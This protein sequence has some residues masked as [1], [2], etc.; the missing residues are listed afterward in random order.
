MA[1]YEIQHQIQSLASN[2]N[3]FDLET[4]LIF[5]FILEI[6]LALCPCVAKGEKTDIEI[7]MC[8]I[9]LPKDS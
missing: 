4:S 5:Y 1:K 9:P 6:T 2:L 8:Y 7:L 3:M